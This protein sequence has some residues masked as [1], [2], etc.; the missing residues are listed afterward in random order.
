MQEISSQQQFQSLLLPL[1]PIYALP[2][3]MKRNLSQKKCQ[4]CQMSYFLREIGERDIPL[5]LCGDASA[6]G[7]TPALG[8][9]RT[10]HVTVIWETPSAG[11]A[12][13]SPLCSRYLHPREFCLHSLLAWLLPSGSFLRQK[14]KEQL[15]SVEDLYMQGIKSSCCI[16]YT[17]TCMQCPLHYSFFPRTFEPREQQDRD[18]GYYRKTTKVTLRKM[19]Y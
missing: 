8:P 18:S 3:K 6:L 10:L 13:T 4:P 17:I 16:H 7:Q 5:S 15:P 14:H 12:L 19:N 2:F 9:V 1:T 11:C